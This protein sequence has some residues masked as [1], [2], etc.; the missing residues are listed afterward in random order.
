MP[1]AAYC[2]TQTDAHNA[3][4]HEALA[5]GKNHTFVSLM[6][7]IPLQFCALFYELRVRPV[8]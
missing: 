8:P 6:S 5:S 2:H 1:P 7:L 4:R 3:T